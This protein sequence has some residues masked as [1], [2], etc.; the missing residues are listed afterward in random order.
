MLAARARSIGSQH[1]LN[2]RPLLQGHGS[3]R[4]TW[5]RAN[6]KDEDTPDMG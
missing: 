3:L 6:G 4:R 1:R 5:R 2:L